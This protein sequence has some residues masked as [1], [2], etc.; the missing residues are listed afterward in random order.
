MQQ[1]H[2]ERRATI[3][4]VEAIALAAPFARIYGSLDDVPDW[5]LDTGLQPPGTAAVRPV[6]TLVRIRTDD[7]LEGIGEAYGLPEPR[8]TATIIGQ[9]RSAPMLL[10]RDAMASEAL[11]ELMFGAQAGGRSHRRVLPGGDQRDRPGP[12]GPA[13]QG[14][15]TCRCTGCSAGRSAR[16]SRSTPARSRSC[17]PRPNRSTVHESFLADGFRAMK[18]K[19]GRGEATDLA[20]AAA[21]AS[22]AWTAGPRCTSTS[23]AR[24]T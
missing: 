22:S 18:L 1:F 8:V 21:V 9:P 11:W 7:G 15:R 23:T 2:K 10:G 14:A 12:V 20:H 24:T 4:S 3:T 17:R 16:P 13:R 19:L 6:T 5:L